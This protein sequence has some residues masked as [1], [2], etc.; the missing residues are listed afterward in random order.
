MP[1]KPKNQTPD[2]DTRFSKNEVSVTSPWRRYAKFFLYDENYPVMLYDLASKGYTDAEI[3]KKMKCS[4]VTLMKWIEEEPEMA[5]AYQ[6]AVTNREAKFDSLIR[7]N[8]IAE[9]EDTVMLQV[10]HK[11]IEMYAKTTFDKFND[12]HQEEKADKN[13]E[14]EALNIIS[15]LM[16]QFKRSGMHEKNAT[17]KSLADSKELEIPRSDYQEVE[18]NEE[19]RDG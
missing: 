16:T 10:D 6:L 18:K 15:D 7:D 8:M 11:F 2:D 4:K 19:P 9:D 17:V 14:R 12:K 1:K 5:E 13:T 3:A